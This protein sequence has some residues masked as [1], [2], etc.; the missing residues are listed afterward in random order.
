MGS[1]CSF[2]KKDVNVFEY[3]PFDNLNKN[4]HNKHYEDE[5]YKC[6]DCCYFKHCDNFICN[7]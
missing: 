3:Y 4:Y 7:C 2:I 6:C 5:H 1:N